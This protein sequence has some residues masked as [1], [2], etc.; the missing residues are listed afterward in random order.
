M[1]MPLFTHFIPILFF[2]YMGIDV[3]RRNPKNVEHRLVSI[4]ILCFMLLFTEEYVR[5]QLP[6]EYSPAIS[7]Y[8]FSSV[9]ILVPGLG[10]H[11]FIKF[12]RLDSKMPR[13]LYPYLFYL[14]SV[15]ILINIF[16][17]SQIISANE[18]YQDGI[19]KLPVYNK[20]YYI[21]MVASTVNNFLFL[22][23]LVKARTVAVIRE[24]RK[25]YNQ[26][27]LGVIIAGIWDILFGLVD[28]GGALPPYPFLYGGLVWCF[29][30]RHTM[31]K[32]DFLNYVD[33]RYEKLFNLNPAAILL[34]DLQGIVKE[35]NPSAKQLLASIRLDQ[36]KFYTILNEKVRKRILS[37]ERIENFEMT[38]SNDNNLLDVLIDGDYVLVEYQLHMIL[39]MRDITIQKENQR[40]I[41]FLAFH[42]PL[43]RLP[44]RRYFHEKLEEEICIAEKR[45][46]RLAVALVDLDYFKET[47]DKYGHLA[48]DE[49]LLH[50]ANIIRETVSHHGTAARLGGD[51][52]VFF[53]QSVSSHQFVEEMIRHL[54][55]TLKQNKLIYMQE[56]IQIGM[57]IGV[58]FFPNNGKDSG[59]LLNSADKAMY[60][61]KRK[62]KNKYHMLSEES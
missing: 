48:G 10:F 57:S 11:F 2:V 58:S 1:I 15:V 29:F 39:I 43:T 42:D 16:T 13:F 25:M 41:T 3:L 19:W 61:A 23:P 18:F 36:S 28:F 56:P 32:Y 31:L 46:H 12:T 47:N 49:V 33:K 6:I 9:G 8:W 53:I 40:E 26:L 30:L 27:I 7:A 59:A 51:E 35:A 37:L 24:L 20:P 55:Q 22:I 50:V 60:Y 52:F 45:C 4:M 54:Q 17:N 38:I 34:T 14:P 62:G 5:N 44:N 21:A